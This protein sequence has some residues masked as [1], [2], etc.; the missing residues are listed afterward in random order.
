MVVVG[1]GA[2][3]IFPFLPAAASKEHERANVYVRL[4]RRK[5]SLPLERRCN[6]ARRFS[7]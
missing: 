5:A 7:R 6:R 2:R 4:L 3:S 1:G